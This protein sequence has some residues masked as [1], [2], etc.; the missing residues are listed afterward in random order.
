VSWLR[1][2]PG[3]GPGAA[4][5]AFALA[6]EDGVLHRLED[7][8][9]RWLLL[10]FYPQDG[11]PGCLREA[12]RF[13]D[14][15]DDFR[16]LGAEVLGCSG[17]GAAS[18][19]RFREACRLRYRLLTDPGRAVREAWQVPHFLRL[20]DGRCSYLVDPQGVLRWVHHDKAPETHVTGGLEFLRR[21]TAGKAD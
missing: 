6:D 10:F 4:A 15:L 14:A 21:A 11:S 1:L 7:Y 20:I 19:R 8:R 2:H 13:N 3:L 17:Q 5:P 16:A 12:C 18:H 9:G